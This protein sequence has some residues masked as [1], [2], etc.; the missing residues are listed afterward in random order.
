MSSFRIDHHTIADVPVMRVLAVRAPALAVATL[1]GLAALATSA[2]PASASSE[3]TKP[4]PPPS[5][6]TGKASAHGTTVQLQG[7]VNPKGPAT[8][9]YFQYGPTAAYNAQTPPASLPAGKARVAVSQIVTGL[10]PGYHY[11]LVASNG[12]GT[13]DGSDRTYTATNEKKTTPKQ[14]ALKFTL[15][16]P[17]VEGQVAGSPVTITGTLSGP[18]AAGHGI[19]LQSS[20][21]PSG[22]AFTNVGAQQT[23]GS[24]GR[25]SFFI[26]HLRRSTRYRVAAVGPQ[27][28]YSPAIAELATVRVT[29]HV[30][31]SP[32]TGLVRLYGTVSPAVTGA[33]VYFQLQKPAKPLRA[34]PPK[35]TTPKSE[36]AE[37]K[38]EERAEEEAEMPRYATEFSAPV[39]RA[40]SQ[41]SRFSFIASV[42]NGGLYRAYVQVPR[43][44]LA[45][46]HSTSVTL[47][48]SPKKK[49]G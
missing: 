25:F 24:T 33:I 21:Y 12:N 27:P 31:T 1:L 43:G 40:T 9:Y 29:L 38:A 49:K 3:A 28:T 14:L 45:S 37:E 30:R 46:G 10:Q 41:L 4:A 26:A 17:P 18:G 11:R 32:H 2:G 20:P 39:K 35:L 48:A 15:T 44:P 23:A 47:R 36:K 19:V 13:T 34:R 22:A 42:R 8:T 5:A 6:S 7:T 16:K